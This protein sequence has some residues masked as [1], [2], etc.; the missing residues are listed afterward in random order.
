MKIRYVTG[1]LLNANELCL[2]HGCNMQGRMGA[3]I[4]KAI[5]NIFPEAYTTYRKEYET[6]G[7]QLGNVVWAE[8]NDKLIANGVTQEF[9]GRD[10]KC[11]IDYNAINKVMEKVHQ[12]AAIEGFSVALPLIGAGLGGGSWKK[13]AGII[14]Q[15]FTNVEPVVYILD[16]IIPN[17]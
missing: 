7:L 2:V 10:N 4:A 17:T 6:N 12:N 8:S 5:R 16:G 11:Y 13:I 14:E 15:N 3:G 1:N 9:Y